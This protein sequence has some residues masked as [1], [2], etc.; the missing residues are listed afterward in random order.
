MLH[1]DITLYTRFLLYLCPFTLLHVS[2]NV[3]ELFGVFSSNKPFVRSKKRVACGT[4]SLY[5]CCR[6]VLKLK[7]K[8]NCLA[9]TLQF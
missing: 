3:H 8:K 1:G 7:I 9:R 4:V 6:P 5:V 2:F